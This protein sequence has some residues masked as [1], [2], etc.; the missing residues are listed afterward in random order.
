MPSTARDAP[1]A[2]NRVEHLMAWLT[3]YQVRDRLIIPQAIVLRVRGALPSHWQ[4]TPELIE[5]T[6]ARLR[7]GQYQTHAIQIMCRISGAEPLQLTARETNDL[8]AMFVT[9]ANVFR[10]RWSACSFFPLWYIVPRLLHLLHVKLP[11]VHMA[12][13][14]DVTSRMDSKWETI[15]SELGW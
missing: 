4:L 10:R 12:R 14:P 2:Y 8:V 11:F 5:R 9:V 15:C 3:H 13:G 1:S 6:L 7:L